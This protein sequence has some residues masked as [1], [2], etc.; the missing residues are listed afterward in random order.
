VIYNVAR[1]LSGPYSDSLK[2]RRKREIIAEE[3]QS[4]I[5]AKK[6]KNAQVM[7]KQ[8]RHFRRTN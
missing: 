5:D 7:Q 8:Q 1:D 6:K 3:T 4:K 2:R